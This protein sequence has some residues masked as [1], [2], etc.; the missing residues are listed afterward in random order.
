M[1]VLGKDEAQ[2][3][4]SLG[5]AL[6]LSRE[7]WELATTLRNLRLIREARERRNEHPA[8][9]TELETTLEARSKRAF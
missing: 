8:W 4:S 3:T 9:A 6:A 1:S 5:D 2:A 7:R